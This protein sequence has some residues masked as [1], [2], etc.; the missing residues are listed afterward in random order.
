M[1]AV[2]A[3]IVFVELEVVNETFIVALG[4]LA[5]VTSYPNV[6]AWETILDLRDALSRNIS[7]ANIFALKP[8]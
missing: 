7:F 3:G 2:P 1:N 6:F 4:A 5:E 8:R